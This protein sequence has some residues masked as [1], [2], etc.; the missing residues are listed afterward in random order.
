M[1]G[2]N[3]KGRSEAQTHQPPKNKKGVKKKKGST[4]KQKKAKED[5]VLKGLLRSQQKD[6]IFEA[7]HD[8]FVGPWT[9]LRKLEVISNVMNG[10]WLARKHKVDGLH[11]GKREIHRLIQEMMIEGWFSESSKQRIA[12]EGKQQ[13][14]V[15]DTPKQMLASKSEHEKEDETLWKNV[16]GIFNKIPLGYFES[17]AGS[18]PVYLHHDMLQHIL[19]K[20]GKYL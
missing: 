6:C 11:L 3:G 4:N 10:F 19:H 20:L 13:A 2:A 15:D 9:D 17:V 18:T 1:M 5:G 12:L 14:E 16:H 7:F 8:R